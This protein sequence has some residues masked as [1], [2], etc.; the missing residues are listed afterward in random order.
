MNHAKGR[1]K[2]LALVS[3]VKNFR[4]EKLEKW[5]KYVMALIHYTVFLDLKCRAGKN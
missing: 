5:R 1:P 2:L 3:K 4:Y